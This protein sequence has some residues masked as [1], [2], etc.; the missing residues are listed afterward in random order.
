MAW[1]WL[2]AAA[3]CEIAWAVLL[4][5]SDGGKRGLIFGASVVLMLLSFALLSQAMRTLPVGTAYGA[6]TGIGAV[7]AAAIGI[8]YF[9]E[10]AGALRLMFLA[11]IVV[12]VVGLLSTERPAVSNPETAVNPKTPAARL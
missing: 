5:A 12:G 7:G 8:L 6:W 11:L 9:G 1:I 2:V 4:K 3:A 10:A